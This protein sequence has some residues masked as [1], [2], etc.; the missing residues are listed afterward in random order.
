[1]EVVDDSNSLDGKEIG[2]GEP[3]VGTFTI[4]GGKA[5]FGP[6][7][8][9]VLAEEGDWL[10]RLPELKKEEGV[11]TPFT[12]KGGLVEGTYKFTVSLVEVDGDLKITSEVFEF[13]VGEAPPDTE[14][15]A[16]TEATGIIDENGA[17]VLTVTASDNVG[18]AELEVDH[19]FES[20]FPEFTVPAE[21][22]DNIVDV[23]E[24]DLPEGI[25]EAD[26]ADASVE[27]KSNG[28]GTW[29][30]TMNCGQALTQAI[31][32]IVSAAGG[33]EV[34]FYLVV[35]DLAGNES[36]SMYGNYETVTVELPEEE[37]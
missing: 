22:I 19:S 21:N 24:G 9:F 27:F 12:L 31:K 13:A 14:K 15:P 7:V 4:Q 10:Y 28:D 36:G 5:Y 3:E 35:R 1:M 32:V 8:G 30:W 20:L 11:T 37:N 23:I 16:I 25:T 18:L 17:L 6:S 34:E 26:L 29:T 33:D 2:Y